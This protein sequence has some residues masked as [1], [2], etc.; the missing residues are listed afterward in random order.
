LKAD[1]LDEDPPARA[2]LGEHPHHLV[3]VVRRDDVAEGGRPAAERV[4][5]APQRRPAHA[6]LL[7][8]LGDAGEPGREVAPVG[9]RAAEVRQVEV[10]V[11]VDQARQERRLGQVDDRLGLRRVGGRADPGDPVA[12]DHDRPLQDHALG[13]G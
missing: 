8:P 2:R 4:L 5:D 9:H 1:R 12:V 11:R 3:E 7:A 13:V 6:R 10:A